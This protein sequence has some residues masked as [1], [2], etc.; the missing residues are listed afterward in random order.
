MIAAVIAG[1][2][3]GIA[4]IFVITIV[5]NSMPAAIL[6]STFIRAA[7]E[8]DEVKIFREMYPSSNVTVFFNSSCL[9]CRP[10]I[11]DYSYQ[12]GTKYADIRVVLPRSSE[13]V[14]FKSI[15]CANLEDTFDNVGIHGRNLERQEIIELLKD[16][17]C[18]RLQKA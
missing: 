12:E 16:P 10:P 18:P 6:S 3:T 7:N 14:I 4:F 2:A 1:L 17:H 5:A 8:L 9:S 11:V 15:G 13:E